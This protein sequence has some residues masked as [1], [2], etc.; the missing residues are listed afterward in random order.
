MNYLFY[1]ILITSLFIIYAEYSVGH[2]LF[3]VNDVGVFVPHITSM[4]SFMLHPFHNTDLWSWSMLDI[5][6]PFV[7]LC[8]LCVGYVFDYVFD[9]QDLSMTT[10]HNERPL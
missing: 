5:N 1:S 3:R 9:L 7:M 2:I 8:A 6:Y 10:Y 4:I